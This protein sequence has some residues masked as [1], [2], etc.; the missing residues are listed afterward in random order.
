[1]NLNQNL[2]SQTRTHDRRQREKRS[3][4]RLTGYAYRAVVPHGKEV[5]TDQGNVVHEPW[6]PDDTNQGKEVPR[7]TSVN[8]PRSTGPARRPLEKSDAG[9]LVICPDCKAEIQRGQSCGRCGREAAIRQ[10]EAER[11][12]AL[13]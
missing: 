5:P 4:G 3:D 8:S 6:E 9:G 12:A 1:M 7:S 13:T 10:R 2:L 11:E